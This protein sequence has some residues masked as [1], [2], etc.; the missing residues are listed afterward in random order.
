M[1]SREQPFDDRVRLLVELAHG[2]RVLNLGACGNTRPEGDGRR[3][4]VQAAL[5]GAGFSVVGADLNAAGVEWLGRSGFEAVCMDAQAIPA[6]GEAFDSI[7]AGELIE[8]L[9]DPGAFLRGAARR[10]KPEGRLVLS[11]PQPFSPVHFVQYLANPAIANEEHT[12][13]FDLQTLGQLLQRCGF[14]IVEVRFVNDVRP[15]EGNWRMQL[16][17][18]LGLIGTSLLPARFRTTVVVAARLR[19]RTD[20]ERRGDAAQWGR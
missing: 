18:R 8:H 9:E 14:E 17:C 6:E 7:V 19:Q 20:F 16:L 10:L 2:P 15:E 5:V 1:T 4:F 3:R 12:C 13:Y 11:T